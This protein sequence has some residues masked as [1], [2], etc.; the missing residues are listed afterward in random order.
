M[1]PLHV[2]RR[3][4]RAIDRHLTRVAGNSVWRDHAAERFRAHRGLSDPAAAA[5]ELRKAD[6]AA[7][8][9]TTIAQHK[10]R[11]RARAA[12]GRRPPPALAFAVLPPAAT[13]RW[14]ADG[15]L[16]APHPLTHPPSRR[17]PFASRRRCWW[18]TTS[19]RMRMSVIAR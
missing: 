13:R 7:F 11:L 18:S 9:M 16:L 10:A 4:L 14:G 17:H 6:E 15:R 1:Q 12:R 2:Y 5:A 3:L 19:G 8:L